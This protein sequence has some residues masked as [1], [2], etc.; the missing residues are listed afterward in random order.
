MRFLR[1]SYAYVLTAAL[2]LVAM[3]ALEHLYF[4]RLS[5]GI[6]ALDM[7]FAGFSDEDVTKWLMGLGA[8]GRE[9]VLVW[10]YLTLDMVLPV[11]LGL[12]LASLI[13]AAGNRL[14]GFARLGETA[15]AAFAVG[16]VMPYVVADYA[17]NFAVVR[18]LDDPTMATPAAIAL[19]SGLNVA[20]FA[21]AAVPVAVL[22][23]L[24]LAGRRKR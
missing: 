7:R 23:T 6:P 17:Q 16:L 15:K 4:R 8:H 1:H 14:P 24:F 5:G 2:L 20:K 22:L 9:A 13:A 18:M 21:L 11:V 19:A 10:H 12:A 3:T